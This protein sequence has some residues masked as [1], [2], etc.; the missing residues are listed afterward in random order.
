ME[1]DTFKHTRTGVGK[2]FEIR[3]D[4]T[5]SQVDTTQYQYFSRYANFTLI[6]EN[7]IKLQALKMQM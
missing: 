6:M 4:Y 7:N 5:R 1:I 2:L 3:Y